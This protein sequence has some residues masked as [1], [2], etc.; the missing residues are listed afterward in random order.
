MNANGE[1]RV[2]ATNMG[3]VVRTVKC[4]TKVTTTTNDKALVN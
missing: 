1:K 2:R 4:S 3:M